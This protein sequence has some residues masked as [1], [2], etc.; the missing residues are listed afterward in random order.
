MKSKER[1]QRSQKKAL[2]H[3]KLETMRNRVG[4]SKSIRTRMFI[5]TSVVMVLVIFCMVFYMRQKMVARLRVD[6]IELQMFETRGLLG[7]LDNYLMTLMTKTDTLFVNGEFLEMV[8]AV[9]RSATEK[10]ELGQQIRKLLDVTAYSLRY[11]EV[12]IANYPGGQIYACLYTRNEQGYLDGDF[13]LSLSEI[14]DT[15]FVEQLMT[16]TCMFSWN[17]GTSSQIGRYI[18]FNRRLLEYEGMTDIAILQI[19]IPVTK[20]QQILMAEKS[21]SVLA[22][23]YLDENG[24]VLYASGSRSILDEIDWQR[25]SEG[26]IVSLDAYGGPCIV[27]CAD[28]ELNENRLVCIAST[29]E[30]AKS[31]DYV[32]PIFITGGVFSILL[33]CAMLFFLSGWLLKG[34]RQ[35][36][37]KTK[38]ASDATDGYEKL[39]RIHDSKEIEELDAA[40]EAMV[41][42]INGLHAEEA[43]YRNAINGVQIE[44]MQEQFN[45]HLLY[46]TL[47]IV[48]HMSMESKNSRIC[49]VL[50]N[51]IHFYKS[52]LNRGQIVICIRD[53]IRMI[54][55]YLNIIRDVYNIDLEVKMDIQPEILDFCAV[56]LFLQPIVENAVLH[57]LMEVGSGTLSITGVREGDWIRFDVED[58]GM[59]IEP[60]KVK[61]IQRAMAESDG[62]QSVSYGLVSV[63]KRLHIFFGD[64]YTMLLSSELG[65]GTHVQIMIPALCEEAVSANLRSRMV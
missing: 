20:I 23:Y 60:E 51:L 58:D 5:C 47:S 1:S 28:S 14:A 50:D 34:I 62:A 57:G 41:R 7:S 63:V 18:A 15:D 48:R 6:H 49:T 26:Q 65:E 52:V 17:S 39:G 55:F 25:A 4:R 42:T 30:V 56:K 10:V 12:R 22:Y 64:D 36:V 2:L 21:D 19:R 45:P 43:R 53:E 13:I 54:Q 46:N 8:T 61:Q 29:E 27:N 16:E 3:F 35:L 32:T 40:Y 38:R 31:V 9:P 11:P 59:G 33:C 24:R 37:E 44:L